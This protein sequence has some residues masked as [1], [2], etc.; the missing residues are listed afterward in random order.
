MH[1]SSVVI[2]MVVVSPRQP[3]PTKEVTKMHILQV[4][5]RVGI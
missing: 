3:N 2:S 4:G 1:N 5:V